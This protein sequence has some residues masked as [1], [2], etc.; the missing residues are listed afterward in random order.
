MVVATH[1]PHYGRS[2]CPR[3]QGVESVDSESN[4][5]EKS[6]RDVAL[7]RGEVQMRDDAKKFRAPQRTLFTASEVGQENDRIRGLILDCQGEALS[8]SVVVRLNRPANQE[9]EEPVARRSISTPWRA[10]STSGVTSGRGQA[11][12]PQLP[13]SI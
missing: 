7:A 8:S 12:F 11:E 10:P 2:R 9:I 5:L 3:G 1:E 6:Q 13:C 4:A